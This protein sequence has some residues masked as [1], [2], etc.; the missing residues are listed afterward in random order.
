[1]SEFSNLTDEQK[2]LI[3]DIKLWSTEHVGRHI[4]VGVVR[5]ILFLIVSLNE[6]LTNKNKEIKELKEIK[7]IIE[8]GVRNERA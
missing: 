2:Y 6:Q 5:K 3:D 1:M 4:T 7:Y 8:E